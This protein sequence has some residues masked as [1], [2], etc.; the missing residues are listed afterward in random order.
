[1]LKIRKGK[2]YEEPKKTKKKIKEKKRKMEWEE[3]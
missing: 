1:M 3:K 2:I